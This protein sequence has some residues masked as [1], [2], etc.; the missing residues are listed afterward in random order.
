MDGMSDEALAATVFQAGLLLHFIYTGQ[1][2][3]GITPEGR[4]AWLSMVRRQKLA[5]AVSFDSVSPVVCEMHSVQL[6]QSCQE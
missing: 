2:P 3:G 6:L 5:A 1:A 4:K